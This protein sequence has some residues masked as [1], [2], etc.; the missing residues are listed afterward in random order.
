MSSLMLSGSIIVFFVVTGPWFSL[1]NVTLAA[2]LL[3]VVANHVTL[4]YR[5]KNQ[6]SIDSQANSLIYLSTFQNI[7]FT[8]L[9]GCILGCISLFSIIG[10][11]RSGPIGLIMQVLR[12]VFE[13]AETTVLLTLS[14]LYIRGRTQTDGSQEGPL[15]I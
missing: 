12:I 5:C 11:V 1:Y 4:Y 15:H 8:G 6:S 7:A 2:L 10:F 13:L 9:A 14:W 3:A